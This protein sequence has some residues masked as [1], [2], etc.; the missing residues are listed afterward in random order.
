MSTNL[1]YVL[2]IICRYSEIYE[3]YLQWDIFFISSNLFINNFICC[4]NK[5][6]F[7]QKKKT[8]V[9]SVPFDPHNCQKY[10]QTCQLVIHFVFEEVICFV[11]K[12]IAISCWINF[13]ISSSL[14]RFHGNT[15]LRSP[16]WW[17]KGPHLILTSV[18]RPPSVRSPASW[19]E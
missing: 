7:Y 16:N 2:N 15:S 4:L 12:S 19:R 10:L 6:S 1:L 9:K 14:N 5:L 3:W 18:H 17:S 8:L 13:K 11:R